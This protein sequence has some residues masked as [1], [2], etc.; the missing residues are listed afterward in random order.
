MLIIAIFI[1]Y[2][3]ILIIKEGKVLQ[4]P[5]EILEKFLSVVLLVAGVALIYFSLTGNPLPGDNIENYFVYIF[6]IGFIAVLW[7]IPNLLEEFR[8]F[9]RFINRTKSSFTSRPPIKRKSK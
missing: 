8:F 6:I 4:D 3:L 2:Y 5:T 9:K 7:T 1:I